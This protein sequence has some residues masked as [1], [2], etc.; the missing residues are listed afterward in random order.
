VFAHGAEAWPAD[1]TLSHVYATVDA[2][3]DDELASSWVVSFWRGEAASA[4]VGG[5]GE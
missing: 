5:V 3:R 4:G 1:T 2:D